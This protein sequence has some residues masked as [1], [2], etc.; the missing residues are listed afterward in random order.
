MAR[1]SV[2]TLDLCAWQDG[3]DDERAGE[4]ASQAHKRDAENNVTQTASRANPFFTQT[5]IYTTHLRTLARKLPQPV[6]PQGRLNEG[7]PITADT[8]YEI[9]T[10]SSNSP[11]PYANPPT[12][13]TYL[14]LQ[15]PFP[16]SPQTDRGHKH[17]SKGRKI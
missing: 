11:K 9:T 3:H 1:R 12:T 5:H 14:V 2:P 4:R 6:E 8:V 10:I 13:D 7:F 15:K 16:Y 17:G